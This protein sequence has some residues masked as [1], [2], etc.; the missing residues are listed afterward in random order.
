MSP[1][2]AGSAGRSRGRRARTRCRGNGA[3]GSPH[4]DLAQATRLAAAMVGSF[5]HSG[6]HPLLYVGDH[7]RSDEILD[8]TYLRAAAHE[9]LSAAHGEAR[10]ILQ[11]HRATLREVTRRLRIHRRIDGSEVAAILGK[12][13]RSHAS[14]E[15]ARPNGSE[16]IRPA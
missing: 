1:H 7:R 11:E 12:F 9:E 13:A 10:R 15:P 4:S 5:G 3:G 14:P 16:Q 8:H 6:P 2:A